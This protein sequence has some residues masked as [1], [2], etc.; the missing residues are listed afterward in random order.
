MQWL[1]YVLEDEQ[2]TWPTKQS[3][4]DFAR[5]S[6][7]PLANIIISDYFDMLWPPFLELKQRVSEVVESAQ[8]ELW[9][10]RTKL[11]EYQKS[12]A[13]GADFVR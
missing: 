9:Q 11:V 1:S 7:R 13:T 3:L 5:S 2:K 4:S 12:H 6:S 8:S 10:L